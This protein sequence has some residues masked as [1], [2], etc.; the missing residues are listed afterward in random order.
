MGVRVRIDS[1]PE[2]LRIIEAGDVDLRPVDSYDSIVGPRA[3][4][5]FLDDVPYGFMRALR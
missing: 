2:T 3:V 5:D 4:A 1:M